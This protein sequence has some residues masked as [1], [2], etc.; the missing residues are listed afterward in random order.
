VRVVRIILIATCIGIVAARSSAATPPDGYWT[1]YLQRS[2]HCR[3]LIMS[4]KVSHGQIT[5]TVQW[6]SGDAGSSPVSGTVESDGTATIEWADWMG[7]V[8]AKGSGELRGAKARFFLF[9]GRCG[10][11]TATGE[12]DQPLK[13]SEQ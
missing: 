8:G 5:G 12:R 13:P 11:Q 1:L 3:N 4:L 7:G 2:E 10:S 9:H 6:A